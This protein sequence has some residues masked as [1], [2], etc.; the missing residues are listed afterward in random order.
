MYPK[1]IFASLWCMIYVVN[2]SCWL[3]EA[4]WSK[5][6][7]NPGMI[8]MAQIAATSF[9]LRVLSGPDGSDRSGA[10]VWP[11]WPSQ[12]TD[13]TLPVWPVR[14]T[15]LIGVAPLA[16]MFLCFVLNL[17]YASQILFVIHT[18]STPLILRYRGSSH[19][20]LQICAFGIW[21]QVFEIPFKAQIKREI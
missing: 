21:A 9:F 8:A 18:C 20:F 12:C 16:H 11:V 6:A 1:W 19:A 7:C 3:N 14:G 13:W 17:S 15:S 10:L 2:C 5:L 4:R